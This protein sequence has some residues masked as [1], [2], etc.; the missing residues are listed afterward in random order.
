MKS[1]KIKRF[2]QGDKFAGDIAAVKQ[3]I[4][5]AIQ[6]FVVNTY[7]RRLHTACILE[8]FAYGT[9]SCLAVFQR[10]IPCKYGP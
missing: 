3:S 8:H 6:N 2:I 4:R 10:R 9:W 7:A 1:G 5:D